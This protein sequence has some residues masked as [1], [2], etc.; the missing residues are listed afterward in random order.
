MHNF[1]GSA[2]FKSQRV[3]YK[4]NQKLLHHYQHSNNQFNSYI[5]SQDIADF[6]VS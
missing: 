5:H 3:G 6:Q 1:S 2:A 4:S